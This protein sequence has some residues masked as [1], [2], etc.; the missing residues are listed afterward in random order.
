MYTLAFETLIYDGTQQITRLSTC[1]I[2]HYLSMYALY[3]LG[4]L[5]TQMFPID[6]QS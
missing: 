3:F 6:C 5:Y 4:K 2:I 1:S